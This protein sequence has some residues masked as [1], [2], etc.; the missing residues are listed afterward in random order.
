MDFGQQFHARPIAPT[1]KEF[2]RFF[3]LISIVI[4]TIFF[5]NNAFSLG[6]LLIL[7]SA[8]FIVLAYLKPDS[9]EFLNKFWFKIGVLLSK[10]T[11]PVVLGFI[12]LVIITPVAVITR[13][14]GRDELR[15]KYSS[16]NTYWVDK[17]RSNTNASD[18]K[19]QF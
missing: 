1:N 6:I 18:F 8:L 9:L 11:N 16:D 3:S 19:N 12:F 14:F 13:L 2:A 7:I 17:I 4:S 5:A 15:I 10:I